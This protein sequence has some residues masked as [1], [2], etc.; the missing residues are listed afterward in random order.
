MRAGNLRRKQLPSTMPPSLYN[1]CPHFAEAEVQGAQSLLQACGARAG[2]G[3]LEPRAQNVPGPAAV[4]PKAHPGDKAAWAWVT[5]KQHRAAGGADARHPGM[6]VTG[7]SGRGLL[8]AQRG[9]LPAL[10]HRVWGAEPLSPYS[11]ASTA[12]LQCHC[13]PASSEGPRS[14][15]LV[16]CCDLSCR[17]PPGQECSCLAWLPRPPALS[18]GSTH[19]LR[20]TEHRKRGPR[21]PQGPAALQENGP[22]Q[23]WDE[24]Q[25]PGGDRTAGAPA[26]CTPN[27]SLPGAGGRRDTGWNLGPAPQSHPRVPPPPRTWVSTTILGGRALGTME[28]DLG[29]PRG[30]SGKLTAQEGQRLCYLNA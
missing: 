27:R 9:P 8:P 3:H 24:P 23:L 16:P 19:S 15:W 11:T 6:P 29:L 21:E 12:Q 2:S 22:H 14:P 13:L 1:C 26:Q 28:L 30:C 10:S 5:R 25:T 7:S 18:G 17:Q 4:R 20:T